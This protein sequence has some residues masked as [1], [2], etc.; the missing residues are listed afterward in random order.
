MRLHLD[1]TYKPALSTDGMVAINYKDG[2]RA[3]HFPRMAT[4]YPHDKGCCADGQ[5]VL[6]MHFHEKP[7]IWQ[8]LIDVE[9]ITIHLNGVNTAGR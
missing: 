8:N 1:S 9:S 3:E 6:V 5:A 4:V 2:S 7:T